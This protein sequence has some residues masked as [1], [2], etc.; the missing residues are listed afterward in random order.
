MD[1]AS[2][3]NHLNIYNLGT[4]NAIKMKLDT[5][6]YLHETFYLV[7]KLGHNSEGVRQHKQKAYQ[8]EP[9]NQVLNPILTNSL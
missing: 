8:N 5:I 6:I 2:P 4:T 7:Y 1:A 3:R 9:E